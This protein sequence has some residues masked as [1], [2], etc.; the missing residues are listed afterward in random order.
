MMLWRLIW[1]SLAN[2]RA[3]A[4]LTVLAVALPMRNTE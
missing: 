2:R 3:T 1:R 4:L